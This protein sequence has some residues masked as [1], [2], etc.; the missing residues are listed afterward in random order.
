M[1]DEA[2]ELLS[3]GFWPD[4]REIHKNLPRARQSTLFSATIPER[5]RSLSRVFLNEPQFVSLSEGQLAPQQIEHFFMV[6]P[7]SAILSIS[8]LALLATIGRLDPLIKD[9]AASW[10]VLSGLK[11]P[12]T[13]PL[14]IAAKS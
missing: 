12:V 3:L 2:D 13:S 8:P 10:E 6:T 4:M 7:F 14:I 9:I 1:L 11:F 5:V